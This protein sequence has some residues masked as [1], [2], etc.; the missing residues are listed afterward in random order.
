VRPLRNWGL[1]QGKRAPSR[2]C[3][4]ERRPR[5]KPDRQASRL[6]WVQDDQPL[7]MPRWKRLVLMHVVPVCMAMLWQLVV[8]LGLLAVCLLGVALLDL[9]R[10]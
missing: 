5:P 2:A 9:V 1:P 3:L 10:R 6:P 8:V 7:L 4:A